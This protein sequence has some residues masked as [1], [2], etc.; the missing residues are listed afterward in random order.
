MF[1]TLDAELAA[2]LA[3]VPEPEWAEHPVY[4]AMLP[5]S[6]RLGQLVRLAPSARPTGELASLDPRGL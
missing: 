3:D 1:D 6:E 5:A 4:S 2:W